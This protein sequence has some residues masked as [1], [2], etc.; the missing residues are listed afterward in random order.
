MCIIVLVNKVNYIKFNK[1]ISLQHLVFP[2]PY[3]TIQLCL[4]AGI[5]IIINIPL[6]SLHRMYKLFVEVSNTFYFLDSKVHT[7]HIQKC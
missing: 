4:I 6:I 2:G 7:D 5:T 1:I 3:V